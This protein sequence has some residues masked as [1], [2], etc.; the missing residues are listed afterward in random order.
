MGDERAAKAPKRAETFRELMARAPAEA[1][2]KF[3]E[4]I[5]AGRSGAQI[6]EKLGPVDVRTCRRWASELRDAGHDVPELT[7]GPKGRRVRKR[8]RIPDPK[9]GF[10]PER[11]RE[12]LAA[13]QEPG[14]TQSSVA[15]KLGLAR[16]QV[17]A[18][19][20]RVS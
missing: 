11:A 15:S 2:A 6:A 14:A 17:H 5:A 1:A 9:R 20:A 18:V 7:R 16:Q 19:A 4:L 13:L 8:A 3:R 12:I 10:A